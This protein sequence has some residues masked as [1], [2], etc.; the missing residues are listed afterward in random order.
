[1]KTLLSTI[2]L[3]GVLGMFPVASAAKDKKPKATPVTCGATISTPGNYFLSGDCTGAGI[4][5]S[6]SKVTL[7]LKRHT[8]TGTGT[9]TGIE[10][11]NNVSKVNITGRGTITNYT[12]GVFL[13]NIRNSV[14]E[15]LTINANLVGIS[16]SNSSGNEIRGNRANNHQIHGIR[17]FGSNDNE[18][19][20]NEVNGNNGGIFLSNSSGNEI[21]ENEANLNEVAGIEL[22]NGS[23]DNEV[24]ENE[25]SGNDYGIALVDS[26]GNAIKENEASGNVFVGI[27]LSTLSLDNEIEENTAL[28]NGS[29]DLRD[30]NVNCDNNAWEDN[31]FGT[32]NQP[33]IE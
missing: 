3:A 17:L 19:E 12:F 28:N 15:D 18:I 13:S 14:V 23:N 21:E 5:I 16:L 2:L 11:F 9:G 10:V 4:K 31:T 1:L 30:D 33:C 32:A 29:V 22:D 27:S 24:E 6:A 26:N 20:E 8:L 25:T 7:D